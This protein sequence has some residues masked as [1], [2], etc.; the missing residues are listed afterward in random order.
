MS[1][2]LAICIRLLFYRRKVASVL[3]PKHGTQYTTVAAII[4][5]S[6][7]LYSG[8]A[9]L[10]LIPFLL[11][12]PIQNVFM[13]PM[14]ELQVSIVISIEVLIESDRREWFCIQIIATFLII[15][16]VACGIAWASGTSSAMLIGKEAQNS[17]VRVQVEISSPQKNL[18]DSD[19][20]Q[21]GELE[22][23]MKKFAVTV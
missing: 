11:D 16:R 19:I 5:E 6:A 2:T 7:V 3:G 21:H 1:L 4:V 12:S 14:G 22:Y 18:S 20:R 17:G 23:G 8:F 13:Q 10:F 9:L 15:Y